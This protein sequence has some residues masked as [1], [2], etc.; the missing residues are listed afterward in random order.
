MNFSS[1]VLT[2]CFLFQGYEILSCSRKPTEDD[3]ICEDTK[4]FQTFNITKEEFLLYSGLEPGKIY[5]FAVRL[6]KVDGY[7]G[8]MNKFPEF[9]VIGNGF[10]YS[11]QYQYQI[12]RIEESNE[13]NNH[14]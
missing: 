11:Q 4:S 3:K 9:E 14:I 13:S 12:L 5:R 6:N 7:Y 2:G 8:K 1:S 10:N